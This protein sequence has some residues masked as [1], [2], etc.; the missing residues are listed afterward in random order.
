MNVCVY[1]LSYSS[2][3]FCLFRSGYKYWVT[4]YQIELACLPPPVFSVS[5]LLLY[6]WGNEY[7]KDTY[8]KFVLIFDL[9]YFVIL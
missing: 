6:V 1:R 9:F 7:M 3:I 2:H 5:F 8:P 4:L